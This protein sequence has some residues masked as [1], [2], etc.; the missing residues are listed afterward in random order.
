MIL[1]VNICKPDAGL[2]KP[3]I[4]GEEDRPFSLDQAES[5]NCGNSSI[6]DIPTL[7][8]LNEQKHSH[9]V[10]DFKNIVG[11]ILLG[12][13]LLIIVAFAIG[14]AIFTLNSA[15]FSGAFEFAKTIATAVI[16]YLFAANSKD[17]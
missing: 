8:K 3:A 2:K 12:V 11:G 14:D 10:D 9:R 6:Q 15:L 16:G 7:M 17:K 4:I 1:I 13:C 5:G